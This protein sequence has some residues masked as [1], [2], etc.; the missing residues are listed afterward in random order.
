MP[1]SGRRSS[2]ETGRDYPNLKENLFDSNFKI[3]VS[4]NALHPFYSCAKIII[5]TKYTGHTDNNPHIWGLLY[6]AGAIIHQHH[7]R[8][9]AILKT[10]KWSD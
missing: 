6:R 3:K 4:K 9:A 1:R 5:T 2:C 7:C 10:R 8:A